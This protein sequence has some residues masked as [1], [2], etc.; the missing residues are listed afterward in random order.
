[1]TT[2]KKSAARQLLE[3]I[4]GRPL[5]LGSLI[6]ALRLSDE[7]SQAVFA[8][9]LKISPSHLCDIEKGRKAISP[10]RAAQFARILGEH[11]PQFVRLAIQ[12]ELDRAGLNFIVKLE[13]A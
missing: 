8:K 2:R 3:E 5:T 13:V 4:A 6:E 11:E 1:M 10:A 9:R 7:V 12:E